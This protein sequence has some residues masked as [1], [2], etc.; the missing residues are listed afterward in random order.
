MEGFVAKLGGGQLH[1]LNVFVF[2]PWGF[3]WQ[4]F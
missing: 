3:F 4:G 1:D 2:I